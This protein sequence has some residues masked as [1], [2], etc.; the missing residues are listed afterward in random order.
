M[1]EEICLLALA[2]GFPELADYVRESIWGL[3]LATVTTQAKQRPVL[4]ADADILW[5][6]IRRRFLGNPVLEETSSATRK[7]LPSAA[8]HGAAALP[9]GVGAAVC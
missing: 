3:E 4:Y 6:E 9:E 1:R 7:Q 2:G 5:F 8:R